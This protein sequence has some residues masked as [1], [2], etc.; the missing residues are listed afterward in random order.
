MA[1]RE[2]SAINFQNQVCLNLE[3]RKATAMSSLAKEREVLINWLK[4]T[5]TEARREILPKLRF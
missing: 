1:G 5:L 3:A 4:G 2:A